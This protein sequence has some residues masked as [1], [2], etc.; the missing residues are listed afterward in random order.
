MR[1]ALPEFYTPT[2]DQFKELWS[3]ATFAFDANVLLDVYRFSPETSGALLG[4]IEKL[5]DRAWAPHQAALEYQRQRH[6][7]VQSQLQ[8]YDK[9]EASWE[10]TLKDLKDALNKYQNNATLTKSVRQAVNRAK[11]ALSKTRERHEALVPAVD[12]HGR[13]SQLFEGR[14]GTGYDDA[15]LT[16]L[17]E[18]AE[19]RIKAKKPPGFKDNEKDAPN[20][21]GDVV[22]WFQLLD[23]ARQSTH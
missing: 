22:I 17:Y 20:K 4:V 8:I 19:T 1:D 14:V 5:G 10:K 13:V 23:L 3:T 15:R 12:L 9:I 21:Y 18:E 7:V 16:K 2:D 11:T 6:N